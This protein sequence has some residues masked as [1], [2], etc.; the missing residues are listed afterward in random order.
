[1]KGLINYDVELGVIEGRCDDSRISHRVWCH[2][3]LVIVAGAHHPYAQL[4]QLSIS[5]LE[6]ATWVLREPGAGTRRVFDSAIAGV[7]KQIKVHRE[8]A[9]VP[10]LRTLVA[11]NHYLSCLPYLDVVKSVESGELVILN[12]PE[13]HIERSLSFVWRSDDSDNPLRELAINE[14]IAMFE[15][16]GAVMNHSILR[17]VNLRREHD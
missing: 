16:E 15:S 1:M 2:D 14:A 5:H 13:I 17:A 11:S 6:Q 10:I 7:L 3:H 8:Y 9:H 12:V 4:K